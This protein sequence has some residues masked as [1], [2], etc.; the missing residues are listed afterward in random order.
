MVIFHGSLLLGQT[1]EF[2]QQLLLQNQSAI[3][4]N[5]TVNNDS[6][7]ISGEIGAD[8]SELQGVF[9]LT[10]DT[11]G[12]WGRLKYSKIQRMLTIYF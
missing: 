2:N 12:I 5:I 6:L 1:I 8:A 9:I 3:L 10:C 7:I 11:L 4:R